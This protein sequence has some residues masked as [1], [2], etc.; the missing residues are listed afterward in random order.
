MPSLSDHNIVLVV[1]TSRAL[2]HKPARAVLDNHPKQTYASAKFESLPKSLTEK[3]S[4]NLER[5]IWLKREAQKTCRE[6]NN[7]HLIKTLD[8]DQN[9]NNYLVP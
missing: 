4:W 9:G 8:S 7:N 3:I 2:R 5:Y 1:K 6:S